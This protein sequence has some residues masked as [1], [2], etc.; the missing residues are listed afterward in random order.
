MDN[1]KT[2]YANS[3]KKVNFCHT[4]FFTFIY[5]NRMNLLKYISQFKGFVEI[6][7]SINF[8][9][10][11]F[12]Y[13]ADSSN[14]C[15]ITSVLRIS[16]D[17]FFSLSSYS[18]FLFI[19][20]VDVNVQS[21][22]PKVSIIQV[23]IESKMEV[24][25]DQKTV[26]SDTIDPFP[27]N[28]RKTNDARLFIRCERVISSETHFKWCQH[29]KHLV[30]TNEY[31]FQ[32]EKKMRWNRLDHIYVYYREIINS[33][34]GYSLKNFWLLTYFH[35]QYTICQAICNGKVNCRIE[36]RIQQERKK[37]WKIARTHISSL[38]LTLA[39]IMS[40]KHIYSFVK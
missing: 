35:E 19:V 17:I 12:K 18:R 38:I 10:H 37:K 9:K 23:A 5:E 24:Q 28:Q 26:F 25:I 13:L 32:E 40:N 22:L 8:H 4:H 14:T 27:R 15:N 30:Y 11:T 16:C 2:L 7:L 34:L 3:E 1:H 39:R 31:S 29:L 36:E 20:V 21:S 33:P 6:Y